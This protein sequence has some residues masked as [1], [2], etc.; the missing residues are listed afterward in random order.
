MNLLDHSLP[1]DDIKKIKNIVN[2]FSDIVTLKP[3]SIKSRQIGPTKDIALILQFPNTTTICKCHQICDEIEKN[4]Q[5][6]YPNC[7]ISIHF[8]PNCYKKDCQNLCAFDSINKK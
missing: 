4:I 2:Q 6:I 7:S 3:N 1:E 8:E 5:S